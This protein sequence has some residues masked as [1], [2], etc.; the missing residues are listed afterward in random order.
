MQAK[1]RIRA[2][3]IGYLNGH[4]LK[5]KEYGLKD[6]KEHSKRSKPWRLEVRSQDHHQ[7]KALPPI[8]AVSSSLK[9][10]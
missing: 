2:K 6:H 3:I 7:L 1:I 5:N 8:A 4:K 10:A 9:A